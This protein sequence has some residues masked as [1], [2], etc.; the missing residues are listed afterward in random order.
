MGL[1]MYLNA[2]KAISTNEWNTALKASQPNHQFDTIVSDL[3]LALFVETDDSYRWLSVSVPV[4]YWR[5]ANHIHGWFVQEVQDGMDNCGEY[6][7][8]KD[9]LAELRDLCANVLC[10]QDSSLL[11]L[12]DGS[13]FGSRE[14]DEWYWVS[15]EYTRDRLTDLLRLAKTDLTVEFLYR[16]SW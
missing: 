12:T 4:A 3:G 14:I 15:T 5:K 1:D 10:E 6:L 13:F 11:P 16:S 2:N 7:V 9:K 8:S